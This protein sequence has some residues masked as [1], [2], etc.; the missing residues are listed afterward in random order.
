MN[1]G[2]NLWKNEMAGQFQQQNVNQ[3]QQEG[4]STGNNFSVFKLLQDGKLDE[5][6]AKVMRRPPKQSNGNP[7]DSYYGGGEQYDNNQGYGYDDQQYQ[8][9]G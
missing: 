7:L 2:I 5:E 8:Y 9:N 4:V 6:E 1:S 3:Q